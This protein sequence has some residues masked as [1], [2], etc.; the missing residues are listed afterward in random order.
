MAI[1]PIVP[2]F[3]VIRTNNQIKINRLA[4]ILP[5]ISVAFFGLKTARNFIGNH[6]IK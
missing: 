5:S 6:Q 3:L 1:D 4:P 2:H